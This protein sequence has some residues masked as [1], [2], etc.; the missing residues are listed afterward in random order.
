M[1]DTI[2]LTAEARE[3]FGKGASRRIRRQHK[4]PAVLYG[5]GEDPIHITLPGHDTMLALRQAN[6]LLSINLPGAEEKLALPKQVQRHPVRNTIEHVDLLIVR[7][8]ERV[9]VAVPVV[10]TGEPVDDVLVNQDLTELNVSAEATSIPAQIEVSIEGLEIGAQ[11][12]AGDVALPEGVELQD[13]PDSLIVS[14]NPAIA[15]ETMLETGEE[16][17]AGEVEETEEQ[18]EEPAAE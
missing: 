7:R 4:I 8:G 11:V 18:D 1:A 15:V 16:E 13:D 6:A 5:R 17:E 10:L 3:E 9:I 14:I 12:L 2:N